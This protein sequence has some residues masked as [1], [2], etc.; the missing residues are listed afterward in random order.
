MKQTGMYPSIL[1]D[2]CM[3][4]TFHN[5]AKLT[6]AN[7]LT[8]LEALGG[9]RK[10]VS[11]DYLTTLLKTLPD[12]LTGTP[13]L[14]I[15]SAVSNVEKHMRVDSGFLFELNSFYKKSFE[16]LSKSDLRVWHAKLL[17]KLVNCLRRA[18]YEH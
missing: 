5:S 3:D 9:S 2:T 12:S 7:V 16:A 13:L 4:I 6:P 11:S 14:H 1:V 15:T 8:T 10:V 18:S 17:I